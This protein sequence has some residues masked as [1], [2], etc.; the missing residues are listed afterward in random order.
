MQLS[1]EICC[2]LITLLKHN[3][4]SWAWEVSATQYT[5]VHVSKY[6][7]PYLYKR[8]V[9]SSTGLPTVHHNATQTI[10]RADTFTWLIPR[11]LLVLLFAFSLSLIAQL[12]LKFLFSTIVKVIIV[13]DSIRGGLP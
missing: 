11:G 7:T 5:Y 3:N 4:Y 9:V 6:T 13:I 12:L 1:Q 2:K 8:V 10:L